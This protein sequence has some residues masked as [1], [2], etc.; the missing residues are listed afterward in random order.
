MNKTVLVTGASVGI[1]AATAKI[2]AKASYNVVINYYHSQADA[3]QLAK[4][5]KKLGVAAFAIKADCRK[6]AEIQKLAEET[7]KAVGKLDV[8]VNNFG[9]ARDPAFETIT[10]A[11]IIEI[12]NNALVSNILATRI[13]VPKYMKKKS[14]VLSVASIYGLDQSART[15]LPIYSAAKAGVINFMQVMAKIYAPNIRFNAVAPGFTKTPGWDNATPEYITDSL[16]ST[17][18]KEWVQPEDIGEALLFLAEAK[19]IDAETIVV[20]AGWSKR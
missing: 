16:N 10:Q 20:D 17:L 18:L 2:F 15:K 7:E 3:E 13:F 5:C 14:A 8:L 11:G 9:L 4:D 1:G 6:E 19:H 12:L